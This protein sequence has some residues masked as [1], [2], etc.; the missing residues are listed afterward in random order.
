LLV[1]ELLLLAFENDGLETGGGELGVLP[2]AAVVV[3][4]AVV[5]VDESALP[6]GSMVYDGEKAAP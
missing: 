5:A 1:V 6:R 2:L 3:V 4:V